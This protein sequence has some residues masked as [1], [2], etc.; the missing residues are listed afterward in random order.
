MFACVPRSGPDERQNCRST[1]VY[2]GWHNAGAEVPVGQEVRRLYR[3]APARTL[4]ALTMCRCNRVGC[5]QFVTTQRIRKNEQLCHWYGPEWWS[6]RNLKRA[7]VGTEKYPAPLR[8]SKAQGATHTKARDLKTMKQAV[9][10]T[11][12]KIRKRRSAA[13]A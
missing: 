5:A 2:F 3:Q 7:N 6:A 4:P 11:I 10:G 13:G 9:K 8:E 12:S 1:S